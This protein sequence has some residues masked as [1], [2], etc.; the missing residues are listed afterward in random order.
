M[1]TFA[2]IGS[3][4]F[5]GCHIV[6]AL[7]ADPGN[8]VIGVS[9]SPEYKPIYLPYKAGDTSR[10]QFHQIDVVRDF[11]RLM[12]LLDE[13]RPAVVIHVAALSEVALSNERPVEYFAINTM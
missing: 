12:R 13:V 8:R 6:D 4:C 10:F 1:S 5:T 9:R 3:N 7:L 2:V 11:P